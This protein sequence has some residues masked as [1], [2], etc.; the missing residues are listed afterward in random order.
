MAYDID[1]MTDEELAAKYGEPALGWIKQPRG[2]T[3]T[4][5]RLVTINYR[6]GAVLAYVGPANYYGEPTTRISRSTTWS[7]RPS[8]AGYPPSS[9]SPYAT[10]FELGTITPATMFMDVQGIIAEGYTVPNASGNERGP[11]RVRDALSTHGTSPS[12]RRSS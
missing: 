9:R 2:A 3:S 4:T 8:A 12:P 7:A 1:R 5:M 11:V 6:T 10:G